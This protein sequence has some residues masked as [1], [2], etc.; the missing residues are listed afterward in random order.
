MDTKQLKAFH[1][2]KQGCS[3]F[4]TAAA[5]CGKSYTITSISKWA[6]DS[7]LKIGI[8]ATTGSAA[9]L[10]GGSTI[11][12]FLGIGLAK[13]SAQELATQIAT[14]KKI[15]HRR[16]SK[17]EI[18][19]IDEISMMNSELFDKIS[20]ILKIL[21]KNK[22]PF[23]GVQMV[24]V[25]DLFQLPPVEG[26]LFF[27]SK[28]WQNFDCQV[29]EL[30]QCHRQDDQ[31]FFNMLNELRIGQCSNTTLTKL[32]STYSNNI[33]N[34]GDIKPTRL[35]SMNVDVDGLNQEQ[36]DS[37]LK[38]GAESMLYKRLTNCEPWADSCKILKECH[39]CVG[40]QVVLTWNLNVKE[41]LCNGSRGVV[42]NVHSNSVDV[43]FTNGVTNIKPITVHQEDNDAT[44]VT[45]IPLKLAFALTINKSQGMTLDHANVLLSEWKGNFQYGRAYTALSRVRNLENICVENATVKSFAAHPDVLAFYADLRKKA[46]NI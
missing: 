12:S 27:K 3:I 23:G 15:V 4:L 20:D 37:L 28:T 39:L 44:W 18:L 13:K 9:I 29:H 16:I 5:G 10:I 24:L 17:L 35:Y 14:Q 2:V 32:Q 30:D 6:H 43:Q 31:E 42:V 8:T 11:H 21:R 40:A 38:D 34:T 7:K 25:G 22:K 1:A 36:F 45:Y 26:D 41:G 46:Q 33:Q 19:V